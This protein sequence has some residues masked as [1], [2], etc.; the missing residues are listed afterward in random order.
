MGNPTW[1]VGV[2]ANNINERIM[3][4]SLSKTVILGA[5]GVRSRSSSMTVF[6]AIPTVHGQRDVTIR[7]FSIAL[8]SLLEGDSQSVKY[9][10]RKPFYVSILCHPICQPPKIP[11]A[12]GMR[13]RT[14]FTNAFYAIPSV[15]RKRDVPI[16]AF[17]I[18]LQSL[19]KGVFLLP[20]SW[21][22]RGV[23]ENPVSD[24]VLRHP[25]CPQ[26]KGHLH[27]TISH[28]AKEFSE[29][30]VI[31]DGF[32]TT[33]FKARFSEI[34]RALDIQSRSPSTTSF[35]TIPALNLKPDSGGVR[36]AITKPYHNGVLR[37]PICPPPKGGR[38]TS[39]FHRATESS[40]GGSIPRALRM[41]SRRAFP[42]VFYAIPSVNRVKDITI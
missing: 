41:Q 19:L 31:M 12:L 2:L 26:P 27:T 30:G 35:N 14:P 28:D 8:Q 29:G 33:D 20:D 32:V 13:F 18:V 36:D 4:Y 24:S 39:I 42:K 17:S 11:G 5:L 38:H 7:A 22:V 23:I 40:K 6:Y 21:S 10:I 25:I 3:S 9:A 34:L 1:M 16:G 15:H 37:Y